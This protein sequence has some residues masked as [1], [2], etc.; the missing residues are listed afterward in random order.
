MLGSL[1]AFLK[2]IPQLIKECKPVVSSL[3]FLSQLITTLRKFLRLADHQKCYVY[4]FFFVRGHLWV[5][6]AITCLQ[7][8]LNKNRGRTVS[9]ICKAILSLEGWTHE[10][11]A[12]EMSEKTVSSVSE[13]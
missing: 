7:K 10:I 4:V 6:L 8:E 9:L 13:Q 3:K 12:S 11:Q 1:W 2:G 5:N